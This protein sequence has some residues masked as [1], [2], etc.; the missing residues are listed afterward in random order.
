MKVKKT[1]CG[2]SHI[3]FLP[4]KSRSLGN[5]SRT[6]SN[7]N[8][9]AKG[10]MRFYLPYNNNTSYLTEHYHKHQRGTESRH[11]FLGLKKEEKRNQD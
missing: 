10:F 11:G 7:S 5:P 9:L 3:F 6:L 4:L 1:D 2:L 8:L